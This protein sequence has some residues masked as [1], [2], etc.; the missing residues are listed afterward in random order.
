MSTFIN[1]KYNSMIDEKCLR[2][3]G[4]VLRIFNRDTFLFNKGSEL[5][6]HFQIVS[7]LAK[8][9]REDQE[10]HRITCQILGSGDA[11]YLILAGLPLPF[12]MVAITDCTVLMMPKDDFLSMIMS[13]EGMLRHIMKY[14]SELMYIQ[15]ERNRKEFNKSPSDRITE[16]FQFLK[17]E[18]TDQ[19]IFSFEINLNVHE[20]AEISGISL[21]ICIDTLKKMKEHGSVKILNARILF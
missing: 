21:E 3:H 10:G 8:F 6:Y 5:E 18:E 13:E 11:N 17:Y 2:S 12:D 7:G 15:M 16:L 14:I 19:E 1:S 9:V 20:I 4:A